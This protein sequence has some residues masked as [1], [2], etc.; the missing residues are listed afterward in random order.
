MRFVGGHHDGLILE[1]DDRLSHVVLPVQSNP[2]ARI[3]ME[4]ERVDNHEIEMQ[5]YRRQS[6]RGNSKTFDI[7]APPFMTG[8]E[9]ISR[10]IAGYKQ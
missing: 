2:V 6:I 8:D 4:G 5:T 10:L 9:L 7:M 1:V 3:I